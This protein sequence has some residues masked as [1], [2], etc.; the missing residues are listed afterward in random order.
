MGDDGKEL[1]G[2]KLGLNKQVALT[3]T[4]W[5]PNKTSQQN[6]PFPGFSSGVQRIL[7]SC[8]VSQYRPGPLSWASAYVASSR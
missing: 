2:A 5:L 7:K 3:A 6:E 1:R 8:F 4:T